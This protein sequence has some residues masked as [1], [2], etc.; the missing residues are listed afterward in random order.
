MN[1]LCTAEV[2]TKQGTNIVSYVICANALVF[3]ISSV[4]VYKERPF[5]ICF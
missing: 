4:A 3:V 5:Y 2:F 1:V